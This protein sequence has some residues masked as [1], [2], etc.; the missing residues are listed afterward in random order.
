MAISASLR[1]VARRAA[2]I[3]TRRTWATAVPQRWPY[4]W[5]GVVAGFVVL[6]VLPALVAGVYF[7]AI[8]SRQ[9]VSEMRFAVR[10]ASNAG[11]FLGGLGGYA[12]A[13]R[14]EDA[15]V[16]ADYVRSRRMFEDLDKDLA[17]KRRYALPAVDYFSR[18]DGEDPIED[19][20]RYWRWKVDVSIDRSSGVVTVT[21]KAFTPED[22]L[23]IAQGISD[24]SE[25]LANELSERARRDSLKLSEEALTKAERAMQA[26]IESTRQT[27]NERGVL[28]AT[29]AAEGLTKVITDLRGK[30]LVLENE[31]AVQQS[32][33]S[34]T[35]PQ[36]TILASRIG[37]LR[38]QISELE[39][40]IAGT[41]DQAHL[42]ETQ[43]QLE[44]RAME[45]RVAEQQYVSAAAEFERARLEEASKQVYLVTFVPPRLAEDALYPKRLL[46]FAIVLGAGLAL[47]GAGVGAAVLVRDHIAI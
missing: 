9:Y 19:L 38:R 45:R 16:I 29:K 22:A 23:A 39:Q 7:G 32:T 12:N 13:Q 24:R 37:N 33:L 46:I 35:S 25:R 34:P 20:V 40:Q 41:T 6:V 4:F 43:E 36:M 18:M 26:T 11:D 31:Y 21:V 47:W 27:R 17:L 30:L 10:G 3:G 1:A 5:R 42:T 2:R 14:N 15:L 28:D 44:R 8:A